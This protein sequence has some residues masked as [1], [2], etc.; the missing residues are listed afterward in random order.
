MTMATGTVKFFNE[1]KGF[2]FII[3][4]GGEADGQD[5]LFFH[6]SGVIGDNPK[7]GDTVEY[8]EGEGQKW[9]QANDVQVIGS[10]PEG[11]S[12]DE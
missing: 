7:E 9:P 10:N 3:P 6:V 12:E 1:T 4:E 2:G 8:T 5:N 11:D